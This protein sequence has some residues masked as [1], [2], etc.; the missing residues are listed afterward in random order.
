MSFTARVV[1][2]EARHKIGIVSS[3]IVFGDS[4]KSKTL[5][6]GD[7]NMELRSDTH[8]LRIYNYQEKQI[9]DMWIEIR[10]LRK[11]LRRREQIIH[12][13]QSKLRHVSDSQ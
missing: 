9:S 3:N 12:D 1:H 11:E 8:E 7:R 6:V 13:L 2:I 10:W 5:G 4:N